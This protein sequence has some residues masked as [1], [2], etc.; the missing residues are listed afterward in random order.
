MTDQPNPDDFSRATFPGVFRVEV[1]V[2]GTYTV[3]VKADSLEAAKEQVLDEIDSDDY[4]PEIEEV[5]SAEIERAWPEP[6][7]FRVMRDGRKYQVTRLEPGDV[8]R[9]PDERGF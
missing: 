7:R 5:Y 3:E 8:P 1:E 9:E 4:L 2:C 6:D